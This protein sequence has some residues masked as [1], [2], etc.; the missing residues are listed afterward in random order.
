MTFKGLDKEKFGLILAMGSEDGELR[1]FFNDCRVPLIANGAKVQN[2]PNGKAARV[3][4]IVQGLPSKTDTVLQKWFFKNFEMSDPEP[5]DTL[6][7]MLRMFE[8]A[9]EPLPE[10][11]QRRY[12]RSCLV[13]LF[14]E[15]PP[16]GL[17]SL[18]RPRVPE[19][20]EPLTGDVQPTADSQTLPR[21]ALDT[22]TF[23]KALVLLSEDKDPDEFL[24]RLPPTVA[25]TIACL[26]AARS[27]LDDE[28]ANAMAALSDEPSVRSVLDAA[29]KRRAVADSS[30][31]SHGLQV[32]RLHRPDVPFDFD[33]R[34]DEI[35]GICTKDFPE[36]AVFIRPL[37]I[38]KKGGTLILLAGEE[39]RERLFPDNGDV[40]AFAGS[41]YPSQPRRWEL[42]FW[43]VCANPTHKPNRANFH[44]D[45][46]RG[47]VFEVVRINFSSLQYDSVREYIKHSLLTGDQASARERL[48]LLNDGLIVGY[49]A[50]KD[51]SR[52]EGFDAGLPAWRSLQAFEFEGRFLIPGP[53]PPAETYECEP[54]SMSIR[55]LAATLKNTPNRPT[56]AQLKLL[57]EVIATGEVRLN[58]ARA[59]RLSEEL[60]F[61]EQ[62]EGAVDA[63][64]GQLR[65][66]P[67]VRDR[68]DQI[69]QDEAAAQIQKKDSLLKEIS[70]LEKSR[71][72]L[73]D[74]LA[75]EE[76]EQR[77][78]APSVS[79]AIRTAFETA[80]ADGP[81]ALAQATVLKALMDSVAPSPR[82]EPASG[83]RSPQT[84]A[85]R[86]QPID[87]CRLP[88]QEA[89]RK[90]GLGAKAAEALS[91]V[92]RLAFKAGLIL[93]VEGTAS[94]IAAAAW[95]SSFDIQVAYDCPIGL[96]DDTQM[97]ALGRNAWKSICI[98]DANLSPIDLYARP[99][100]DCMQR[101]LAFDAGQE[102]GAVF[103]SLS[104]GVAALALPTAVR[105]M[106]LKVSLDVRTDFLTVD[107]AEL[108]LDELDDKGAEGGWPN[109]LWGPA[110]KRVL[111]VLRALPPEEMALAV[112]YLDASAIRFASAER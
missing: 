32:S 53:L 28:V 17:L 82:L 71:S 42:G 74:K 23:A 83:E 75:A 106:S 79:K 87:P 109:D 8:A 12:A 21:A 4:M 49:Q 107:A 41:K 78:L 80:R 64:V 68:I 46:E 67:S 84:T 103:L 15:H 55:K 88:I 97:R 96:V 6:V 77:A 39:D 19:V 72:E 105:S 16:E 60:S 31:A 45:S 26:H 50:G 25:A 66:E 52:D 57:Q 13:H 9:N 1:R 95:A 11:V 91:I 70:K 86:A 36:S 14:S 100:L 7:E 69:V 2:L 44:I 43:K 99:M 56:H 92:G 54:L 10:D 101:R 81:R 102:G 94:R 48:L 20:V 35:F 110:L 18:L 59:A 30:K 65:L 3:K 51:L 40:M 22:E 37:A 38:R 108:R 93:V 85:L 89:L 33:A 58:A 73:R 104:D 111:D 62:H 63:I 90:I 76:K 47:A 24:E 27:G 98:L 112:S 29:L 5:V 34:A 61:I